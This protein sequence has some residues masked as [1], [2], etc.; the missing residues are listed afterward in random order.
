[1]VLVMVVLVV[2][3]VGVVGSC[4]RGVVV[5]VLRCYGGDSGSDCKDTQDGISN[6]RLPLWGVVMSMMPMVSVVVV[7]PMCTLMMPMSLSM[8]LIPLILR[9]AY[10]SHLPINL[11]LSI[12]CLF[13]SNAIPIDIQ[14]S[15]SYQ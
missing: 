14:E 7:M 1:M 11:L 6:I 12:P 4:R 10:L 8:M 9:L 13:I 3:V 15:K 2:G 5:V